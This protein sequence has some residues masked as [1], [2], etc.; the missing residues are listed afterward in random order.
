MISTRPVWFLNGTDVYCGLF[1]SLGQIDLHFVKTIED[2]DHSNLKES[3]P[4][5]Y[6]IGEKHY[7]YVKKVRYR[8]DVSKVYKDV[9]VPNIRDV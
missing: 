2:P 4:I 3:Q 1:V 7:F 6:G 9:N 8:R 5:K